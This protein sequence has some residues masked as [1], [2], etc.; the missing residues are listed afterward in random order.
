VKEIAHEVL[1][2]VSPVLSTIVA[3]QSE[4]GG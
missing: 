4:K 2:A 1:T 3:S